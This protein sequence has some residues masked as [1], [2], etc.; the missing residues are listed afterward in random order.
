MIIE[1]KSAEEIAV[2]RQ[3]GK[4]VADILRILI[5]QIKPGMKTKEMDI[6]A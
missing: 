2:M 1:I 6:I 5:E 4:I 3:S